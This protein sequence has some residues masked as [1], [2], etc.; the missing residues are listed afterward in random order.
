MENNAKKTTKEAILYLVFGVLTTAVSWIVRFGIMWPG[1]AILGIEGEEGLAYEI[2]FWSAGI[3]SWICAVL[4][5]F[6][7]NRAFV[8]KDADQNANIWVQ[9]VQFSGGRLVSFLLFEQLLNRGVIWL[10]DAIL[11]STLVLSTMD[12]TELRGSGI[13]F[14]ALGVASVVNIV[15]NYLYGKFLVFRKAKGKDAKQETSDSQL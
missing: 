2:L 4:F 14:V 8:F 1:K 15:A 3:V 5:A 6:F 12:L 13:E 11:P 7:T 9:L 10:L